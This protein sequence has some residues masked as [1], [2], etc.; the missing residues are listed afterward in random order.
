MARAQD[1]I[2]GRALRF[3]DR[4]GLEQTPE[5]YA[6]AYRYVSGQDREFSDAVD[7]YIDGGVRLREEAMRALMPQD[8]WAQIGG[9]FNQLATQ[10]MELLRAA[11]AVTGDLNR[12]LVQTAAA[13]VSSDPARVREMVT[14]MIERTAKAEA[15][16]SASLRQAQELRD[17][18]DGAR[19]E[20]GRDPLTGLPGPDAMAE[21]LA[22]SIS[23][24]KGCGVALVEIDQVSRVTA[25]HGV[26]IGDRLLKAVALTLRDACSPYQVGRW[27]DASFL[28]LLDH[29]DIAT[30]VAALESARADMAARRLKLR[31]NSAPLG[32]VTISAGVAASRGREA[33]VVV[34]AAEQLLRQANRAGGSQVSAEARLVRVTA[35]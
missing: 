1:S 24:A 3:L 20:I 21:R 9:A 4:H 25:E 22:S 34:G 23:A 6:F 5:H 2:G 17:T 33:R 19:R 14:Y 35:Q 13:L 30:C 12:D 31:E 11:T 18:L 32:A 29:A 27:G 10:L 28:V 15:A 16:L 8:A 26:G 7:H